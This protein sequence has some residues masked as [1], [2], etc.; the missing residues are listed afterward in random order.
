MQVH[1]GRYGGAD[2]FE[3]TFDAPKAGIYQLTAGVVTPA[4]QEHV[5]VSAN[6]AKDPV[7][8]AQPYAVGMWDTTQPVEIDLVEGR[9]VLTFSREQYFHGE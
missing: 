2:S 1:Y 8:S 4:W 7:D 9:N 6:G 3:S 5:F